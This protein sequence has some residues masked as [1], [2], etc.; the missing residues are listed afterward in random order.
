M[1]ATRGPNPHVLTTSSHPQSMFFRGLCKSMCLAIH[2]A[3]TFNLHLWGASP[4][5]C[6][7]NAFWTVPRQK[8]LHCWENSQAMVWRY[9]LEVGTH[10]QI[11]G[12]GNSKLVLC[13]QR[14]YEFVLPPNYKLYETLSKELNLNFWLFK[15]MWIYNIGSWHQ[16]IQRCRWRDP[17]CQATTIPSVRE[18][19]W[20]RPR[21]CSNKSLDLMHF[22]KY[23]LWHP[24][25]NPIQ[26]SGSWQELPQQVT[27]G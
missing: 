15:T 2:Q 20:F 10:W 21:H 14:I 22:L 11:P 24:K 12:S 6:V 27:A 7:I 5:W 17:Y 23:L 9:K 19:G 13:L 16:G 8:S 18:I 3:G 4:T 25:K 1:W 26:V